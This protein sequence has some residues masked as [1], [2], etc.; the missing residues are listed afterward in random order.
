MLPERNTQ[1]NTQ[2]P[3]YLDVGIS[4]LSISM[5]TVKKVEVSHRP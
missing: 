1:D 5:E 4:E 3:H 2:T